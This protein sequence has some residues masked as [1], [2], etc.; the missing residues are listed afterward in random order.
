M[1]KVKCPFCSNPNEKI[2]TGCCNCD[3]TGLVPFGEDHNFKTESE[4]L[5]H[6]PEISYLD[7]KINRMNGYGLNYKPF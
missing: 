1:K 6:D 4:A 7:L 5:N 3:H 2:G